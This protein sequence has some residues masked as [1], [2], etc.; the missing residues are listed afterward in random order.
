MIS[1]LKKKLNKKGFTLAELLIVIAIIAI[2]VAIAIPV[3]S[4]QLT[5][6]KKGVD[7]ANARSAES[8]AVADYLLHQDDAGYNSFPIYY[9]TAVDANQ[10]LTVTKSASQ[11]TSGVTDKETGSKFLYVQIGT[12]G[13]SDYKAEAKWG[14]TT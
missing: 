5:E 11:P 9:S 2:L 1:T 4:A 7:T 8:M 3:F 6:A 12:S 10:N 13:G 14:S